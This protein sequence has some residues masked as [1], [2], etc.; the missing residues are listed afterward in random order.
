MGTVGEMMQ[1]TRGMHS[2]AV[3]G[4]I[5]AL[6]LV[7]LVS[8]VI[9][10]IQ[11]VYVP[12]M[13]QQ[14]E[15]D[16]MDA[17]F[18]Q[19]SELK[20]MVDM[21][22][23]S[24]STSPISSML[25]LGSPKMPYFL[26]VPALGKVSFSNSSYSNITILPFAFHNL[27]L[28]SILYESENSYFVDQT[29][30]LEGGGIIVQQPGSISVMRADPSVAAVNEST[31]IVLHVNLPVFIGVPGKLSTEGEGKCF[32]R[33]NYSSNRTYFGTIPTNCYIRIYT[34]FDKAWNQSLHSILGVYD[35]NGYI[36]VNRVVAS[37]RSYVQI[38]PGTKTIDL[39]LNVIQVFV[40]IGPGWVE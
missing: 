22:A 35:R 38:A 30:A 19:F 10:M 27:T 11:L 21:Q 20:S 5:E 9:S 34:N 26:T 23:M 6:L 36:S 13:M 37:P 17:V 39:Y 25:T 28:S 18:N 2:S 15:A 4:V 29:Y 24:R 40:Q 12:Q 16:H 8:I 33:T 7:A 31:R 1:S 32:I 14:K 3:A